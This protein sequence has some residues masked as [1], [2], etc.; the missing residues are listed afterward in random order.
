MTWLLETFYLIT[1]IILIL[2]NSSFIQIFISNIF[3]VF[4]FI[5]TDSD[6]LQIVDHLVL[7]KPPTHH[8][9]IPIRVSV[10]VS[11]MVFRLPSF[12]SIF[13]E[14][15]SVRA[16]SDLL[17][18]RQ[19]WTLKS[20]HFHQVFFMRDKKLLLLRIHIYLILHCINAS[21]KYNIL[22]TIYF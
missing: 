3:L 22:T 6:V 12:L 16:Q 9:N 1:T 15:Q 20:S 2:I 5:Q 14:M 4:L 11:K 19:H 21:Y 7:Q 10:L 18:Q 17:C 8:L 13:I